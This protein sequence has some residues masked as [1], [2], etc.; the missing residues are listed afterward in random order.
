MLISDV[1]F[2]EKLL[3]AHREGNLVLFAGAGVS[4]GSPSDYPDFRRLARDVAQQ[5]GEDEPGPDEPL[6]NFFGKLKSQG[7]DV[8]SI[9][10]RQLTNPHSRPN[11]LHSGVLSLFKNTSNV[12]LVTTNFDSHFSTCAIDVL[13]NI[14]ETYRAPALPLGHRLNGI[15]YLHGSVEQESEELILTDIDFGRAYLTEGWAT[16]FLL[17]LFSHYTVLFVGYSHEDT[18]LKYL[19]R[20][21]PPGTERYALVRSDDVSEVWENIGV[22]K[23]VFPKMDG[24][25]EYRALPRA[26]GDWGKWNR[27]GFLAH[28]ER[29]GRIVKH[30]HLLIKMKLTTSTTA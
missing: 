1:N 16:R 14:P 29:I 18:I 21:L 6:E 27:M 9:V 11:E 24:G 12:R 17:E 30:L 10:K 26:I 25:D 15:V 13:G 7:L 19:A 23:I 22:S 4:M 28:D 8:H 3:A 2:P 20:G 5:A